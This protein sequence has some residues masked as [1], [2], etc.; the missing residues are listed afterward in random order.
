MRRQP[1]NEPARSYQEIVMQRTR[2]T[3]VPGLL[4]RGRRV[5]GEQ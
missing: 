2:E 4:Q 5:A 1:G 3:Q